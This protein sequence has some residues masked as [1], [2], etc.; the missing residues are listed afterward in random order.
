MISNEQPVKTGQAGDRMTLVFDEM[1]PG[2]NGPKGL[3]R[4]GWRSRVG[5]GNRWR[6]LVRQALGDLPDPWMRY[7]EKVL[8]Q[9][10][11]FPLRQMDDDN[12]TSMFK[13]I[14][15]ALKRWEVV[16]DDSPKYVKLLTRQVHAKHRDDRHCTVVIEPLSHFRLEDL[17][18][19]DA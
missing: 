10:T 19:L 13:L 11:V 15:D 16:V 1:P 6:L 7:K 8:I 14:G 2:L 5:Y 4:M 9:F 18:N 12:V 17:A 3:L